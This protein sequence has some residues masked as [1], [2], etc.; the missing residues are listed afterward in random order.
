LI[1]NSLASLS[2]LAML[3]IT[4]YADGIALYRFERMLS[5]HG[6]DEQLQL[7]LT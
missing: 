5:R 6:V 1:E 7:C 4:E 3:L 2:V